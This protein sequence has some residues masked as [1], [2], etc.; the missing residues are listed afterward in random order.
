[1]ITIVVVTVTACR[2]LVIVEI[3]MAV[4]TIHLY[5]NLIQLK[6]DYRMTEV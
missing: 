4:A 2:L 6:S 3:D 5:V 1:M